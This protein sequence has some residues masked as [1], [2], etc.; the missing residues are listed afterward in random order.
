MNI[1]EMIFIIG[2]ALVTTILLLCLVHSATVLQSYYS[3]G[4]QD[5][6]KDGQEAELHER[7][8]VSEYPAGVKVIVLKEK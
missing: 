1:K 5:G 8:E 3:Y 6:F 4:Y 7:Y 2:L